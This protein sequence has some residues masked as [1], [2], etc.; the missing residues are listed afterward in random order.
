MYTIGNSS[1]DSNQTLN[2][3]LNPRE[4][5][6]NALDSEPEILFLSRVYDSLIVSP[7]KTQLL[8][9]SVSSSRLKEIAMPIPL[10]THI[11]KNPP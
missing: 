3:L 6:K 10:R 5:V 2:L 4:K 8:R 7:W 9:A 1:R 11:N